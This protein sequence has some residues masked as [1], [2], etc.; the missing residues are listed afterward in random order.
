MTRKI[1]IV[2]KEIS[3]KIIPNKET[4]EFISEEVK[5]FKLKTQ[6]R[7]DRLGLDVEIFV[8]GSF[9]KKTVVKK[10]SYDVDIFLRFGRS[11]ENKD[12]SKLTKKILRWTRGVSKIHGSRDYFKIK[13]CPW[14]YL[15]IVP[16]IKVKDPK[17]SK[18]ITD[19][20]ASHV[21]FLN[22]KVKS[23]KILND[24]KI[25]KAFC[26]ETRTYG[27]ESYVNGFSGYSIELLIYH[28]KSF[29]KFLRELSKK[30]NSKLIIDTE[31]L[32]KK[33]KDILIEMNGSKLLSPIVLIDPTFKDR[34]VTAAL[35]EETLLRFKL[36]AKKFLKNPSTKNFFSEKID[37]DKIKID[38]KK[39]KEEFILI[40]TRTKKQE[41]DIAGTKLLKFHRHL[42]N[43]IKKYFTVIDAGFKYMDNREGKSYFVVKRKSEIISSGPLNSNSKNAKKFKEAH[44]KTY[45]K[46]GRLYSKR[47][48]T[49]N[50]REF[51]IVWKKENKRKIKE[52]YI[53]KIRIL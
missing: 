22:K 35:S 1:D 45:T 49:F 31:K 43:E 23:Q 41:G 6:K 5:D 33:P 25:A 36:A 24:I 42:I 21:K 30:R 2:L 14:F 29:E 32:Y 26:H 10:G 38:A 46:N 48:L 27:A 52:M 39:N 40:K 12:L 4:I 18:N 51:F 16:V 17:N 8:G 3:K 28:Y 19:L 11:Y 50:V 34:N 47:K 7:I 53:S 44:K 9:A 20:S 15:E 37:L 13:I